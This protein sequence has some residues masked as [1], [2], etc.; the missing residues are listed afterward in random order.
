[1]KY[2]LRR[3]PIELDDLVVTSGLG[4]IFPAGI[5]IGLVRKIDKQSQGIN[6]D[7]SIKPS[8]IFDKLTDVLILSRK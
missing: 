4:N 8:V 7:V 3:D 6:Q 5:P 1:M 2:L